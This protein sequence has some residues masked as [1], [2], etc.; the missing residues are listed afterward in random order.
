MRFGSIHKFICLNCVP[1]ESKWDIMH[2]FWTLF[3]IWNNEYRYSYVQ[4]ISAGINYCIH[5]HNICP[6]AFC[7][8]NEQC[9]TCPKWAAIHFGQSLRNCTDTGQKTKK[10]YHDKVYWIHCNVIASVVL[11]DKLDKGHHA[12]S[13]IS[14]TLWHAMS[15]CQRYSRQDSDRYDQRADMNTDRSGR[16]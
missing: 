1:T 4:N 3:A 16:M 9:H 11:A 12:P 10:K 14:K 13:S 5:T 2:I 6:E 15:K 8:Q 7:C